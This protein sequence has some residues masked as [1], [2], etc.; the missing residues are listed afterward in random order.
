VRLSQLQNEAMGGTMTKK[1]AL[2]FLLLNR[3]KSK[4]HK[5]GISD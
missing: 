1:D 4:T 2:Y 5:A 3:E